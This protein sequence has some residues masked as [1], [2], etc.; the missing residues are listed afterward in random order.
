MSE[1]NYYVPM[2]DI[3]EVEAN[4]FRCI[5]RSPSSPNPTIQKVEIDMYNLTLEMVKFNKEFESM[6]R[7]MKFKLTKNISEISKEM[8]SLN[9]TN[10]FI[11][12]FCICIFLCLFSIIWIVFVR[13]IDQSLQ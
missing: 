4:R 5:A 13:F 7:F 6:N 10:K 8:E 12:V 2:F 11:F 3:A 1:D 9:K